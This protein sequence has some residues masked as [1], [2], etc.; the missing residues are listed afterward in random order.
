MPNCTI[1]PHLFRDNAISMI[2]VVV[3]GTIKLD[4][5]LG[6]IIVANLLLMTS[7]AAAAAL[8]PPCVRAR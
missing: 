6:I 8:Y 7:L 5:L 1:G 3:G 4:R 2:Q